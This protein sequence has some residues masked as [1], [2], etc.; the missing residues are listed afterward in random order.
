MF[1][2]RK[3]KGHCFYSFSMN[4]FLIIISIYIYIYLSLTNSF[5]QVLC[6]KPYTGI[7]ET[8]INKADRVFALMNLMIL[9]EE[10]DFTQLII[11]HINGFYLA[12]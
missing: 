3:C 4:A 9:V 5:E 1:V 10:A 6:I 7:R 2:A 12:L 8:I 11:N